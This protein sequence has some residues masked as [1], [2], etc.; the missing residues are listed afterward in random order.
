MSAQRR[1]IRPKT[2]KMVFA[3][4]SFALGIEK[5]KLVGQVSV[6]CDLV[7]C[8]HV[9]E[10][11]YVTEAALLKWALSS[12]SHPDT[13]AI[14]LKNCWKRRWVWLNKSLIKIKIKLTLELSFFFQDEIWLIFF[15]FC[16]LYYNYQI[17]MGFAH[18]S[19]KILLSLFG[20]PKI[21]LNVL[22]DW[23]IT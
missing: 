5:A 9:S 2:L 23:Q 21:C 7:E 6:S 14:W 19:H 8:R 22:I 16:K 3:A 10:V 12:L 11:W 4:L 18:T 1:L 13:V 15:F 17:Y 20:Y